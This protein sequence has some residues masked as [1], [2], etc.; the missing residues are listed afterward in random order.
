MKYEIKFRYTLLAF[1]L[2]YLQELNDPCLLMA[3]TTKYR[4]MP[5]AL[6][7]HSLTQTTTNTEMRTVHWSDS[8]LA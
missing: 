7:R 5:T 8:T 1:I 3:I 4:Y 6:N 2:V